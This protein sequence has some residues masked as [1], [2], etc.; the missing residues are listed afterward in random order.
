MASLPAVVRQV[1]VGVD[2]HKDVHVAAAVDQV[3]RVLGTTWVPTTTPGRGAAAGLG[4]APGCR[5]ALWDRG[6]GQLWGRAQPL[7]ATAGLSGPGGQPPQPAGPPAPRQVRPGG[8]RGRRPGRVGRR[9]HDHAQGGQRH[10]GD[11]TGAAGGPPLGHQGP[12]PGRQPTPQPAGDRTRPTA[13]PAPR[14]AA[15]PAGPGRGRR[16]PRAADRPT[17][18]D[19]VHPARARPP[20]PAPDRRT[21]PVGCATGRPGPQGARPIVQPILK[22]GEVLGGQRLQQLPPALGLLH[23]GLGCG[24]WHGRRGQGLLGPGADGGGRGCSL[25]ER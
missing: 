4:E 2:S 25:H 19:Q 24:G 5:A 16:P 12:R 15:G 23:P 1:T 7:A 18:R 10:R 21:R 8:R 20:L 22:K 9:G 11:A 3:G 17:G 13:P 6:H 14:A